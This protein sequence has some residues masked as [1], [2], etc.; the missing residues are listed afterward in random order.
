MSQARFAE[1][2][3]NLLAE[4]SQLRNI[5]GAPDLVVTLIYPLEG[6][7]EGDRPRLPQERG[8]ARGGAAGAR[9][10]ASW[11]SPARSIWCR[12]AGASSAASRSSS[13]TAT[14][15]AS[16]WGIVSAVVD[17]DRLYRD[18]GLLDAGPAD[19]HRDHRPRRQGRERRPVLRRATVLAERSGRRRGHAAL[20]LLADRRRSRRA[21]GTRRRPTPGC[22]GCSCWSAGALIL[23][24]I[25]MTGRLIERAAEEHRRAAAPRGRAGA[26]VAAARAGAR[27]LADRRLGARTSR[28]TSC[29]G[30]T[31]STSSTAIPPTAG[32]AATTHWARAMHPDD[33][34]A[35]AARISERAVDDDGQ[36][37]FGI[38]PAAAGRRQCATSA[39]AA[40]STRIADEPAQDRRRQ[41]GRDRRRDA[42]TRT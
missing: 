3:T 16:F 6:Q 2:P 10:A 24:P 12:A 33:L 23:V 36:L 38:P 13:T 5:A 21:A 30:T 37:P 31:A 41:L 29:S 35:R 28:P 8:A 34:G 17:V 27:H 19:R 14:A 32:R 1:L 9:H 18:S 22:C 42:A 7:R 11:C 26:A 20:R 39:R 15:A 4:R 40:R 25:V